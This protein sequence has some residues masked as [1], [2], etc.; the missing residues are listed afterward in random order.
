LQ[1]LCERWNPAVIW[2]E[3][4]SVGSVN[5]EALQAEGLPVR[6]FQTTAR[7]KTGL[8]EGLALAIERGEVELLPDDVLLNELASYTLERMPG[9]GYRYGAAPGGHD[10]TV[11]ALALAWHGVRY[12]GISLGFG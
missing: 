10:D 6:P 11:M 3:E 8:I 1:A 4:N 5:I 7:S 2:A 12:G 9:G